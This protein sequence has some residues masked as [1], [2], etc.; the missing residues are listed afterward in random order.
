MP[1]VSFYFFSVCYLFLLSVLNVIFY[2]V[3][4]TLKESRELG[5]R[6]ITFKPFFLGE[7]I[8]W[9]YAKF[10]YVIEPYIFV[11]CRVKLRYIIKA[12]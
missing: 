10:L 9:Y 5:M 11:T 12:L 4:E 8:C 1:I 2:R 6:V 3:P 7:V